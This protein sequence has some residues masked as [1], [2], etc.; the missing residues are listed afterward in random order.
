MLPIRTPADRPSPLGL[1][2]AG[3]GL[4]LLC[5]STLLPRVK[6]DDADGEF[7]FYSLS[8]LYGGTA[9]GF[10]IDTSTVVLS[11]ALLAAVGLSAHRNPALRWPSRLGAIGTAA[12]MAAFSYHPVT[13]LRQVMEAYEGNGEFDEEDASAASQIDITADSGVYLAV[14]AGLLLAL[15]T[16]LMHTN[17]SRNQSY[18]SIQQ[19]GPPP[20]GSNPT[21][22]VHPG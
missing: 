8:G 10:G 7:G 14:V 15:S 3:V 13:V 22:T 16:F 5:V 21:V 18:L 17:M 9:T 1:A 19:M 12:L 6:I 2:V 20:P 11:V 4:V